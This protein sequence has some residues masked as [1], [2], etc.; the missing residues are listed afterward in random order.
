MS[1]SGISRL[2]ISKSISNYNSNTS[3]NTFN[4]NDNNNNYNILN[5]NKTLTNLTKLASSSSIIDETCSS[6]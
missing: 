4:N 2:N 1:N 3:N 6:T 5:I